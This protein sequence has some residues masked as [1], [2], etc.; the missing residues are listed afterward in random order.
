M[1]VYY[2]RELMA[3]KNWD[4]L[5]YFYYDQLKPFIGKWNITPDTI[6]II[7]QVINAGSST[8]INSKL[9]KIGAPLISATISSLAQNATNTDELDVNLSINMPSVLNDLNMFLT[10]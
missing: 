1:S 4:Y 7:R 10:I 3:V 8:L 9:P 2:Y 5:S 6:A